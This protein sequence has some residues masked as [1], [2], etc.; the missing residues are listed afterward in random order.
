MQLLTSLIGIGKLLEISVVAEGVETQAHIP[1][2]S[3]LGCDYL[4]GYALGRPM[5]P[6]KIRTLLQK[7]QH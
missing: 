7:A 3:E 2:L 4:Q 1:V 5:P 6:D